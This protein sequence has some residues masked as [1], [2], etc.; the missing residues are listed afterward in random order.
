M[1]SLQIDEKE[2]TGRDTATYGK[3]AVAVSVY[4]MAVVMANVV[5]ARFGLVNV[6]FGLLVTAGTYAAGFALLARDFVHRYGNR[7]YA[8]AAVG[9]GGLISWFTSTPELAV[10]SSTAFV[11]AELV[12][13]AVFEPIRNVRGFAPAALASN[14]VSA[15]VDTVVF[16]TMAGF[17][18]TVVTVGGQFVGKVFWA[19]M[20]PLAVFLIARRS[21]A[22][23]A[24]PR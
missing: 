20:I 23:V 10:A 3:L 11:V 17:P 15:P 9:V 4:V 8:L 1:K 21:V 6:G 7:W 19:T 2:L 18:L 13:L 24:A 14:I 16:L 5:T 12:D 22:A